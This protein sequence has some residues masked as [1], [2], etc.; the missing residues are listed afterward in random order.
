MS[1]SSSQPDEP[2]WLKEFRQANAPSPPPPPAAPDTKTRRKHERFEVDGA[3]V[4]LYLH[5]SILGTL[6]LRKQNKAVGL[7]DLSEGGAHFLTT[8]RLPVGA[9]V[10][11]HIELER[12]QDE[13]DSLAEVRWSHESGKRKGEFHTGVAFQDMEPGE[14]TRIRHMGEYFASDAYR[15]MREA[16]QRRTGLQMP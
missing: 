2:D 9:R 11:I 8:E 6:G 13:I 12:M 3:E 16:R 1:A 5:G 10:K 15:S 4:S 14:A 7:V